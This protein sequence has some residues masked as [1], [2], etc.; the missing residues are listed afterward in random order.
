MRKGGKLVNAFLLYKIYCIELCAYLEYKLSIIH[1][2]KRYKLV[3][4]CA[5]IFAV[6]N[7]R[8]CITLRIFADFIFAVVD[9]IKFI[10]FQF[11]MFELESFIRGFMFNMYRGRLSKERYFIALAKSR[12]EKIPTWKL[13]TSYQ[14]SG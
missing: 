8:G 2:T 4:V 1:H 10:I 12:I 9:R 14:K 7:F 3:T 6:L 11:K 5:E 13:S